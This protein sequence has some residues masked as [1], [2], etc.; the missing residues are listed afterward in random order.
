MTEFL[1][2]AGFTMA[3]HAWLKSDLSDAEKV[4]LWA[5][6]S[7]WNPV[8]RKWVMN[9]TASAIAIVRGIHPDTAKDHMKA[10]EKAG[11]IARERKPKIGGGCELYLHVNIPENPKTSPTRQDISDGGENPT[12]GTSKISEG[13]EITPFTKGVKSPPSI[14]ENNKEKNINPKNDDDDCFSSSAERPTEPFEM[15]PSA[16]TAR[17]PVVA[18]VPFRPDR[19][20]EFVPVQV[21]PEMRDRIYT[22]LGTYG[23]EFARYLTQD[24]ID[25]PGFVD[26]VLRSAQN[27][28]KPIALALKLLKDFGNWISPMERHEKD[29]EIRNEVFFRKLGVRK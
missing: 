10:I 23:D 2:D 7:L 13:G 14:K 3:Y 1:P 16:N 24:M 12:F 4:T 22:V 8:H 29:R 20:R 5:I 25:K 27:G 9:P 17:M 21:P 15:P 11:F 26:D 6:Y 19:P 18:S 28:K